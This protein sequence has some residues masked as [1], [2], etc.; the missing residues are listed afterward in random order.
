MPRAL[1][2]GA[3][4]LPLGLAGPLILTLSFATRFDLGGDAPWYLLSLVAVGYVPWV[5]V[6]L[7]LV[8]LAIAAQLATLVSGRYAPFP[9]VRS[10]GPRPPRPDGRVPAQTPPRG[11]ARRV[12]T[13]MRRFVRILG[14]LMIVAG[15]GA[16]AWAFTV[17]RWEDP[18]TATLNYYDQRQLAKSF[19]RQLEEGRP[20]GTTT[21]SRRRARDASR[22]ARSS[23]AGA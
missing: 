22:A 17:W 7:G 2:P 1:P 19:D 20:A 14:T 6:L 4:C 8:W 3:R 21:D 16:L 23:G 5:A 10:R 13:L 15:V 18:F 12:G 9:D 11:A